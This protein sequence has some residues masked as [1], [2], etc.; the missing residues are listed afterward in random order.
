MG[1]SQT[2][3]TERKKMDPK[4]HVHNADWLI[5][6]RLKKSQRNVGAGSEKEQGTLRGVDGHVLYVSGHVLHGK[7]TCLNWTAKDFHIYCL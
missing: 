7:S 6:T 3:Y 4:E 2:H 1:E 5:N